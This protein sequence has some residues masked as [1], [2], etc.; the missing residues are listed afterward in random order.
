MTQLNPKVVDEIVR[1]NLV[2]N[3]P[4]K[5]GI[6]T[7]ICRPHSLLLEIFDVAC[8]AAESFRRRYI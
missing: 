4:P 2:I 3:S 8:I 6:V 5:H 1:G 7:G